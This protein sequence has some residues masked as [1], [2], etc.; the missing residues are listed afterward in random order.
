VPQLAAPASWQR[1]AGSATPVGTFVQAPSVPVSA[2]DWQA[3][4]Q[5]LSQHTPC[6]QKVEAHSPPAEQEAPLFFRPHELPLQTLGGRQLLVVVV[7]ALKH[8]VTL[9]R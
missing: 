7:H 4:E 8:D 9:Q 5:A 6:A 2:H 1:P 3:P